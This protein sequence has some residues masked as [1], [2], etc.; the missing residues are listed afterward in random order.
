[1]PGD[2]EQNAGQA[3]SEYPVITGDDAG[4]VQ[5]SVEDRDRWASQCV[6]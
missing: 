5:E 2:P 6:C 3:G 1:M 4:V